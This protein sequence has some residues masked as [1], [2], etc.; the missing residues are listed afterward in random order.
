MATPPLDTNPCRMSAATVMDAGPIV[1]P[2][3]PD[4][5]PAI[6]AFMLR[7]FEEDYGYGY[8][9]EWHWDYDD[10]LGTYIAPPRHTLVLAL[11]G[12]G[13]E[14]LG[15]AALRSGGPRSP[16]WLA[17][18]YRPSEATAQIFRVFVHAGHRRRGIARLLVDELRR[19]VREVGGYR[20]ICLHT[21]SAVSFW[22][23]IGFRIV[24]DGRRADPPDATVHLE[25]ELTPVGVGD[26]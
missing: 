3:S 9:P 4:D 8:R 7:I 5:V 25:L 17:E 1:R 26:G 14:I 11:D 24:H 15:T 16:A 20:M 13:G 21:E 19:F 2:A 23:S 22:Q 12:A 6:R 10:L 18:R